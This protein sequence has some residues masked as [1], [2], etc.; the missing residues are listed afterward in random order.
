[1]QLVHLIV[2]VHSS[3]LHFMLTAQ[4]TQRYRTLLTQCQR[5]CSVIYDFRWYYELDVLIAEV[6]GVLWQKIL[7]HGSKIFACLLVCCSWEVLDQIVHR[8]SASCSFN[9]EEENLSVQ[10]PGLTLKRRCGVILS[11][12]W[13]MKW[14][15][16]A[17]IVM[18][19]SAV[20][21]VNKYVRSQQLELFINKTYDA[22]LNML[23]RNYLCKRVART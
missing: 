17:K 7:A 4:R 11:W 12:V 23:W 19:V 18:Q 2:A 1:M 5:D 13:K 8:L 15:V 22:K 10:C 16:L 20:L 6:T 9:G 21:K 14:Q 3:F